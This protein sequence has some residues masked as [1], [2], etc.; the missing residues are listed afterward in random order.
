MI[1]ELSTA[2]STAVELMGL[3]QP[4]VQEELVEDLEQAA[5]ILIDD[6]EL[7]PYL[8]SKYFSRLNPEVEKVAL[9]SLWKFVFRLTDA[10]RE[11]NSKHRL[12][13][14]ACCS[15]KTNKK[16]RSVGS[17]IFLMFQ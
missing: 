14:C 15:R 5:G 17:G 9:K 8:E 10:R 7:K 6:K 3:D 2:G 4:P 13:R 16:C 12:Q 11:K 1:I